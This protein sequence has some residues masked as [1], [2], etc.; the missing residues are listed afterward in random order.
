MEMDGITLTRI[1]PTDGVDTDIV[2]TVEFEEVPADLDAGLYGGYEIIDVLY[3][4]KSI[5]TTREE[6]EWILDQITRRL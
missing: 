2:V 5:E 3:Q 4:G 1:D 6:D